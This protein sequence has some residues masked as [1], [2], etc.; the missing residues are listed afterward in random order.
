MLQSLQTKSKRKINGNPMIGGKRREGPMMTIQDQESDFAPWG[1]DIHQRPIQVL[2]V[3]DDLAFLPLWKSV[4]FELFP[5][6]RLD[7]ATS[8]ERAEAM[9]LEQYRIQQPYDLVVADIFLAGA[10]TG[11][12]L[13]R[14]FSEAAS[15]FAFVSGLSPE[16]F[17]ALMSDELDVPTY[18]SKPLKAKDCKEALRDLI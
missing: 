7:W 13:W 18:L 9:I 11:I 16:K 5:R 12:E 3:E 17:K 10:R 8:A 14:R 15:R 1:L 4:V 2:V 6:S